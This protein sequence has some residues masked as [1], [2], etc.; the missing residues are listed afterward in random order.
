MRMHR[1]R[2]SSCET[3]S[4]C[5]TSSLGVEVGPE[6]VLLRAVN[7]QHR[8]ILLADGILERF[9]EDGVVVNDRVSGVA[10]PA[11]SSP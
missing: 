3:S 4:S 10:T 11:R 7:F 9:T 2:G 8:Q 5:W 1:C 6:A